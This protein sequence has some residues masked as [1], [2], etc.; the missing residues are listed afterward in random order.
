MGVAKVRQNCLTFLGPPVQL[1][2]ER[3]L[4][5]L[6]KVPHNRARPLP[7]GAAVHVYHAIRPIMANLP[8][9]RGIVRDGLLATGYDTTAIR[10]LPRIE[11][12]PCKMAL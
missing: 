2:L 11:P 5:L 8:P 7:V 10:Q 3:C 1:L 12:G 6:C 9:G 4:I